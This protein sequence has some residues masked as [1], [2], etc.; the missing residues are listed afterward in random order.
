MTFQYFYTLF[1]LEN[2]RQFMK[3]VDN[4]LIIKQS[5]Y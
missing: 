3:Y 1:D 4:E 5:H 2:E